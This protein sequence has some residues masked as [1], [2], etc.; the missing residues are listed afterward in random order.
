[1]DVCRRRNENMTTNTKSMTKSMT[2]N[3][4]KFETLTCDAAALGGSTGGGR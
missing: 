2:K 3:G 1:M 4:G